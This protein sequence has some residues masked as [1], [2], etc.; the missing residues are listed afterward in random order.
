M[1]VAEDLSIVFHVFPVRTGSGIGGYRSR[2]E[3]A[4]RRIKDMDFSVLDDVMPAVE[5]QFVGFTRRFTI[6]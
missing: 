3:V 6:G 2:H 4:L 5:R 1:S